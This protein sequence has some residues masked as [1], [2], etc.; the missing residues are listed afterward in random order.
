M[1]SYDYFANQPNHKRGILARC[2]KDE[3][4][5]SSP[6]TSQLKKVQ[7]CQQDME[8]LQL[9][10]ELINREPGDFSRWENAFI[11]QQK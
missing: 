7:D 4:L 3:D 11:S 1:E 6:P 8:K 5:Y 9:E 10:V 2:I